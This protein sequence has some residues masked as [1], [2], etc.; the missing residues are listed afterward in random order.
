M[1]ALLL[2]LILL[3]TAGNVVVLVVAC[4]LLLEVRDSL[5]CVELHARALD[6]KLN[7]VADT[8]GAP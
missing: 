5:T 8:Q 6:V 7:R 1:S 2:A 4:Y 3:V